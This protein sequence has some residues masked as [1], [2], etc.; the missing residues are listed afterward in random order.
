MKQILQHKLK[1]CQTEEDCGRDGMIMW[2]KNK[3][4]CLN[5]DVNKKRKKEKLEEEKRYEL[6]YPPSSLL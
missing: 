1:K 2:S 3:I 4:D 5:N 6:N